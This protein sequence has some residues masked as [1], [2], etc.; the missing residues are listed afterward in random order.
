M[1]PHSGFICNLHAVYAVST[2]LY[3]LLPAVME[4]HKIIGVVVPEKG[5]GRNEIDLPDMPV[6][7]LFGRQVIEVAEGDLFPFRDGGLDSVYA[8]IDVLVCGFGATVDVQMSL[9][10]RGV[11][12]S[13]K[14]RQAFDQLSVLF[15]SYESS[16]LNR[17]DQQLDLRRFKMLGR[18][19][20]KALNPAVFDDIHAE[21]HKLFNVAAERSRVG[22]DTVFLQ[23]GGDIRNGDR[24]R[25]IRDLP[26]V[27]EQDERAV[28]ECHS[29]SVSENS[30]LH[31]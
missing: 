19:M 21:R 24:V 17:V 7:A 12:R 5:I 3:T 20:V 31:E 13:G 22:G 28:C 18:H 10:Q 8:H 16:R 1:F 2:E 11:A 9:Q 23:M 25:F 6:D 26:E 14:G 29:S 15:R 4:A 27:F 30:H